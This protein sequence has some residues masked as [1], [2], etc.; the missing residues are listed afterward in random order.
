MM[1]KIF[2]LILA[3]VFLGG[4]WYLFAWNRTQQAAF[5]VHALGRYLHAYEL[6][7]GASIN[8]LSEL[9]DFFLAAPEH[10]LSI[11][12]SDLRMRVYQGYWYDLNRLDANR[13]VISASPVGFSPVSVEFGMTDDLNLRVNTQGVDTDADSYEEVSNWP[14]EVRWYDLATQ[15]QR[16]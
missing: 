15:T 4:G 10:S 1:K 11:R 2:L 16:R 14:L 8:N 9:P 7:G 5:A 6:S 3:A 13:F 12:A